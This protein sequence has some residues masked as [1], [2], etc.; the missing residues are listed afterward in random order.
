MTSAPFIFNFSS[1]NTDTSKVKRFSCF[2]MA[3]L[4]LIPL[5]GCGEGYF[6]VIPAQ[7]S[8]SILKSWKSTLPVTFQSPQSTFS[9]EAQPPQLDMNV[10][11]DAIIVWAQKTGS[12]SVLYK[13]QL[14]SGVWVHPSSLADS[15]S[16]AG[17]DAAEVKVS[18]D[19]DGNIIIGWI[20]ADRFGANQIFKSEYRSGEWRH[21]SSLDDNI[22]PDG[23]HADQVQIAMGENGDAL[24]VW[25]QYDGTRSQVYKSEYRLGAWIHPT[26]LADNISPD[27]EATD[28]PQVAMDRSGDALIVWSQI[29][30][31]VEQI[32]KSEYRSGAWTHPTGIGDNIS[33]DGQIAR[34]PQVAMDNYG[35]ALIVWEQSDGGNLQ[36]F[37]AEYRGTWSIPVSLSDNISPDLSD[38]YEPKVSM[39]D[40][41]E[42]LIVWGQFDGA[43]N[44]IFK[45]EYRSGSWTHPVD[46][47][48][49]IS[50]DSRD[51]Y[52][53]QV[54]INKN[55]DSVIVWTQ[56]AGLND[57]IFKSEY[58]SGV[59]THPLDLTDSISDVSTGAASP[60]VSINDIGNTLITW[61][62][63][64][65]SAM[66]IFKSEYQLGSWVHPS[67]L[68]DNIS[69]D[70]Q[71]TS[72]PKV[73]LNER[74][75]ALIVWTQ[76]DGS[77]LQVFKSEYRDGTWLH[78]TGLGDSI[79]VSG[80]DASDIQVSLNNSGNAIIAWAQYDGSYFQAFKSLYQFGVWTHPTSLSDNISPD[81]NS[82][83]SLKLAMNESGD[84]V[85][86]WHQFTGIRSQIFK[87]EYRSGIWS[88]PLNINDNISPDGRDAFYP[89]V[90]IDN[91]GDTIIVWQQ[92]SALFI[93]IFKSEYRSGS[94][95]HPTDLND[96]ISPPE[97]S[98]YPKVEM[99][100]LGNALIVWSQRDGSHFQVYKSEYRSGSWTHPL[101]LAD[102]ISPD[103]DDVE[104]IDLAMSDNGEATIAWS[105]FDGSMVQ[106]FKSTLKSGSWTHPVN[107]NDNISADD[108]TASLNK[109]VM[110]KAGNVVIAYNLS[111]QVFIYHDQ[112]GNVTTRLA[113][114]LAADVDIE[115]GNIF[116][117]LW[118]PNGS[119]A[120]NTGIFVQQFN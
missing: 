19:N 69:L 115:N 106:I 72:A 63:S 98:S 28:R 78:P 84:A 33:L 70:G 7:T 66:Q 46:L 43:V 110:D 107:L 89:E 2:I 31:V 65:T 68:A 102:N 88:H 104:A 82:V 91:S 41:G 59:W 77:N 18:L 92:A 4:C 80:Q 6:I 14:R 8:T 40:N 81:G 24:I 1:E 93:E 3:L 55:G 32:F 67:N 116:L 87:S 86:T 62:Q 109:V 103:G 36:I 49:N 119:S 74:G 53:Y 21:P 9:F 101:N 39:G 10:N 29:D 99:D 85:I 108:Q 57:A 51:A 112:N 56:Y 94:W 35:A 73:D 11:G 120:I 44:Q 118:N 13:S 64:D 60:Q 61:H 111:Q 27:G 52:S 12:S 54:S 75:D 83:S 117:G 96:N 20:Q 97:N 25:N 23:Q 45:S 26:N 50:P 114:G 76:Y 5:V 34:N 37:K 71:L 113:P 95:V 16:P 100:N 47:N 38:S 105:Q 58:R 30:G 42:A 22:S 90:A 79:S 48:D 15:F 17:T